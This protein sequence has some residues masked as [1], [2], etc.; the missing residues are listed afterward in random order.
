MKTHHKQ[1][2][3]IDIT[4]NEVLFECDEQLQQT[5]QACADMGLVSY[6]SCA[7]NVPA[8][9]DK[10]FCWIEFELYSW[11]SLVSSA[12]HQY[13]DFYQWLQDH[14][15]VKLLDWDDGHPTEDDSEWV[16][17]GELCW[18]ASVRFSSELL[19]EF[20]KQILGVELCA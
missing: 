17:G 7:L 11:Q 5:L 18:S 8:G 12:F 20:E 13:P 15:E 19:P 1:A 9:Q 14:C 16:S 6:N 2:A 3:V 10:T 4:D